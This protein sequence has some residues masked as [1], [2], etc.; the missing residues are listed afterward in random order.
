MALPSDAGKVKLPSFT[1]PVPLPDNSQLAFESLVEIVLSI[2]V[3][4]SITAD[5]FAVTVV[6]VAAAGVEP[7]ITVPSMAP[8]LMSTFAI[9]IL[10]V[11]EADNFKFELE[12]VVDMILS[13]SCM[14]LSTT[15]FSM[16]TVPVPEG[17]ITRLSLERVAVI[18][19]PTKDIESL[20]REDA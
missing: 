16:V 8:P 17:L 5:V 18:S 15:S 1:V 20:N 14:L 2:I 19:L 12:F 13:V 6:N 11:P 9:S 10:P 4:P 7:P 3:T